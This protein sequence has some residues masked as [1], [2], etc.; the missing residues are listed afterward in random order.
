MIIEFSAKQWKWQLLFDF[1][2]IIKSTGFAE[3]MS[4]SD[5]RRSE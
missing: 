1:L 5:R 3:K 4:G 2:R